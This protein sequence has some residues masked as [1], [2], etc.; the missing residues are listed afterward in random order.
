ML[1]IYDRIIFSLLLFILDYS[2]ILRDT[3]L[4]SKFL[5]FK[6]SVSTED[7]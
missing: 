5:I 1:F 4:I 6:N 7:D 3:L 2:N